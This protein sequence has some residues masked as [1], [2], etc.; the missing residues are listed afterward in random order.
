MLKY[1]QNVTSPLFMW[2]RKSGFVWFFSEKLNI[3]P[4][5]SRCEGGVELHIYLLRC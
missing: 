3:F 5:Q 2:S 1:S 4:K